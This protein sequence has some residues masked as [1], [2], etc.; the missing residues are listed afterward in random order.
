M[1]VSFSPLPKRLFEILET[2]IMLP[3]SYET[4]VKREE[5]INYKIANNDSMGSYFCLFNYYYFLMKELSSLSLLVNI[6]QF[7][8]KQF[9]NERLK[10]ASVKKSFSIL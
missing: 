2:L 7:G 8:R 4:K 5:S 10:R 9:R 3:P 1:N 6:W